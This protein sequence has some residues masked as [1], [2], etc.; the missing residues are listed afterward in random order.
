[1]SQDTTT[2]SKAAVLYTDSELQT[3]KDKLENCA[4]ISPETKGCYYSRIALWIHYCNE[5][6]GVDN[7]KV[8]DSRLADYGNNEEVTDS[9]LAD[10]VEWMVS[11][12]Y[13]ERICQEKNNRV[14]ESEIEDEGDMG[15]ESDMEDIEY[16]MHIQQVLR[17]ELQGVMCYWRIQNNDPKDIPDPRR[18]AVFMT[19]WQDIIQRYPHERKPR[20]SEPVYN[21]LPARDGPAGA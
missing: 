21:A 20:H 12:G 4:F 17:N 11:S 16:V 6:Y 3:A 15:E 19:K 18:S 2:S 14:E 13:A 7:D 5:H 1:M 9:R 8:T 10:Y